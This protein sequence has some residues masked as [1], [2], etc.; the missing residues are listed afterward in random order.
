MKSL[1]TGCLVKSAYSSSPPLDLA[2]DRLPN[3]FSDLLFF[4][5]WLAAPPLLLLLADALD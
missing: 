1:S 2:A 5:R 4:D 3:R